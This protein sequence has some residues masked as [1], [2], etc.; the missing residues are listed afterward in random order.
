MRFLYV[1]L[2]KALVVALLHVVHV[3]TQRLR[4]SMSW[5]RWCIHACTHMVLFFKTERQR[6]YLDNFEHQFECNKGSPMAGWLGH[7]Q[8]ID[9]RQDSTADFVV[10][11]TAPQAR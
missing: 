10:V 11:G 8:V 3:A 7:M 1:L 9:V 6:L 2:A 4:C 5:Q